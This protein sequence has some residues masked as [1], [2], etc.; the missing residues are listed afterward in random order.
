M[1]PASMVNFG[2]KIV[3][4]GVMITVIIFINTFTATTISRNVTPEEMAFLFNG[5]KFQGVLW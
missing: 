5:D 4:S 3:E 2:P 1:S